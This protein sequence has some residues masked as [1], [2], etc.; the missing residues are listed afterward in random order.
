MNEKKIDRNKID[1]FVRLT[2]ALILVLIILFLASCGQNQAPQSTQ[3]YFFSKD[4]VFVNKE[5]PLFSKFSFSTVNEE[6]FSRQIEAPAQIAFDPTQLAHV[7]IPF[8][9]RVTRSHARLGQ[10]VNAGTPLFEIVSADF[11]EAQRD[12]FQTRSE[13][14]LAQANLRRQEELHKNGVA[15][16]R[17]L[18]EAKVEFEVADKE[19]HNAMAI[20][21]IFHANP[22]NMVVGEPLVIRSPI[23]GE[24][25]ENNVVLG[26]FINEEE[27]ITV[28]NSKKMWI[29]AHISEQDIRFVNKES[30]FEF[31]AIAFP[32]SVFSAKIFY[33]GSSVDEDS[34]MIGVVGEVNNR[35][36][37]LRNRMFATAIITTEPQQ[38]IIVPE[39]AIMQGE[40]QHFVFVRA[41]DNA[42]IKRYVNV[43]AVVD[44]RA[45]IVSGLN[46]GEE[47]ITN[48]GIYII[49]D[50]GTFIR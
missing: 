43:E 18:E 48:G 6:S 13:R 45:V 38:R 8:S 25:S 32:D 37:I 2:C 33:I 40:R 30:T 49:S 27:A 14:D 34:R 22:E 11:I 31:R 41:S 46:E 4:T 19:Y 17:D 36:G 50:G 12:F 26:Q 35:N 1:L 3:D 42:F 15:A 7:I 47:I 28:A 20:V 5:S 16:Q 10:S 23:A 39:T 21:R 44:G 9:G 29:E 24:I